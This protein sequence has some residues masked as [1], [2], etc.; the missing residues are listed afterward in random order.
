MGGLMEWIIAWIVCGFFAAAI[1]SSKG[2]SF[3]GWLILGFLFGLFALLAAGFMPAAA[4]EEEKEKKPAAQERKCP[5]C[6]EMIKAEAKLCRF[7]GKEVEP[8]AVD[9]GLCPTCGG[10]LGENWI[11]CVTC[12]KAHNTCPECGCVLGKGGS[13]CATCRRAR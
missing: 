6:A 2:R 7:C 11:K 8:T 3:L 4:Q 13:E 5:Y 10:A 9:D 1:A 12:N